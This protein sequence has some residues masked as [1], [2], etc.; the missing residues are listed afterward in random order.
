MADINEAK[1]MVLEQYEQE[2]GE[3]D[4]MIARLRKDLGISVDAEL[5]DGNPPSGSESKPTVVNIAQLIT[6]GDL[7]GMTQV[8]AAKT[9]LQRTNRQP[10]SL[11]DIAAALYRGKTTEVLIEGDALRNLS[12]LLSRSD[13]LI[14]VAKGR[15]GL[16]EW[17][18]NKAKK[19]RKAKDAATE[20][21]GTLD[22]ATVDEPKPS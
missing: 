8:E 11:Q 6:P 13:D 10:L 22:K 21:N 18:P 4:R 15:W 9:T 5:P 16:S 7:F 17:Y 19:I 14:S 1:R 2:R 3:L 20:T 12:S